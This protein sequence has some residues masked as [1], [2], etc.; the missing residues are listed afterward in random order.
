MPDLGAELGKPQAEITQVACAT[1]HRGVPIPRQLLDTIA[2][3]MALRGAQAAVQEYR[4]LRRQYYGA[5]A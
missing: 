4:G 2:T 5:Q 3:T 1:C